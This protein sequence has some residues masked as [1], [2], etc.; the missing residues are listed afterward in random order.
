MS[1]LN[2]RTGV[3][4]FHSLNLLR[5]TVERAWKFLEIPESV[6]WFMVSAFLEVILIRG[7]R[8]QILDSN[9]VNSDCLALFFWFVVLFFFVFLNWCSISFYWGTWIKPQHLVLELNQEQRKKNL[10]YK[11]WYWEVQRQ[12]WLR[13]VEDED[14]GH[15][16]STGRWKGFTAW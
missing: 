8:I 7:C 9:H 2:Y 15:L 13:V 1:F 6:K 4:G 10:D 14:R 16:D 11:V 5:C 3:R 12:K